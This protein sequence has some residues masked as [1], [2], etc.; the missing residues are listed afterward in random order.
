MNTFNYNLRRAVLHHLENGGVLVMVDGFNPQVQVPAD[1]LD[2]EGRIVLQLGYD[3]AIPMVNF[4]DDVVGFSVVLSFNRMPELCVV[5]WDAIIGIQ[6]V[7]EQRPKPVE[8][9]RE[10]NVIHVDFR[11]KR[12]AP[13]PEA[14]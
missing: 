6:P 14:C 13:S 2:D 12:R 9:V 10:G 5:P 3:L 8:P 1:F 4:F 7:V 11:A